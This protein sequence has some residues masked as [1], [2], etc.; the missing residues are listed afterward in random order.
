M[1]FTHIFN[2]PN[3]KF[4]DYLQTFIEGINEIQ[5]EFYL[6]YNEPNVNIVFQEQL[7]QDQLNTLTNSLNTY[8][9]PQTHVSEKG[10]LITGDGVTLA[11]GFDTQILA[12]DST[13]ESGLK[14]I[15][16]NNI[17]NTELQICKYSLLLKLSDQVIDSAITN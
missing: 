3:I 15:N 9:P 16:N 6:I 11:P 10:Q 4:L 12:A 13:T 17:T 2:I 1:P 8:T 5:I 14:W 7:T